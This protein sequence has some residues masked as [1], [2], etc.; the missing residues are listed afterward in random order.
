MVRSFDGSTVNQD[1]LDEWCA[2]AL[3]TPTAG[4][5]A[6]VRMHTAGASFV[7]DYF[8]V[9]TDERWRQNARRAD[10]LQR[11]GGLVLVTSRPQDYVARYSEPDKIASGLGKRASWSIPYWHTDAAMATMALLLL[12]EEH[13]FQATIWGNFRREEEILA[14]ADIRE[15]ELFATVLVGRA[16]GNDVA[17]SSLARDVPGT[18]ERVHRIGT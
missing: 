17:S 16:D 5:S 7:P 8:S 15:E 6:G 13:G 12:I 14:W 10:G 1:R 2:S 18:R 4:N 11:A 3:W 9:A